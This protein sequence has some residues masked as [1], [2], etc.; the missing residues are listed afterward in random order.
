MQRKDL[1]MR[2]EITSGGE[3]PIKEQLLAMGELSFLFLRHPN[4]D[5]MSVT[6]LRASLEHAVDTGHFAILRQDDVPRA[7]LT[8][9][10]LTKEAE[11]DFLQGGL[12]SSKDWIAGDR[13]WLMDVIAPY[14]Q[15]SAKK[16]IDFWHN[17]LTPD[18]TEYRFVRRGRHQ[19]KAR[20]YHAK[21]L[22][23]GRFGSTMTEMDKPA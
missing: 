2:K 10:F 15:G 20:L 12:P 6:S 5:A 4:S 14:R 11:A 18:V 17:S 1:T 16:M 23:T 7:A 3:F 19:D 22:P 8:Y 21:R 13:L 9:A